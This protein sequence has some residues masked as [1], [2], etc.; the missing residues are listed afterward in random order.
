[1]QECEW[2]SRKR[3]YCVQCKL[4][5][6]MNVVCLKLDTLCRS[7]RRSAGSDCIVYTVNCVT[8]CLLCVGSW[9]FC[10]GVRLG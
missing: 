5:D 7:E 6:I 3:L 8:L 10:A 4:C 9:T 1:V 2:V